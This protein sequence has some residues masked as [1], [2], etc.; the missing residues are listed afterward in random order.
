MA[1]TMGRVEELAQAE[2]ELLDLKQKIAELRK[3]KPEEEVGEYTFQ[4]PD[5]AVTLADNR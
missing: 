5:R 3:A 1:T 4:T 2:R